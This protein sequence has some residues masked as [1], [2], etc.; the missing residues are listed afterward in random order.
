MNKSIEIL[1]ADIVCI[2]AGGTGLAAAVAAAE[3]G[4]KV[5]VLE[6][7][8]S[9][10]GNTA[11]AQGFFAAE[12]STQKRLKID[13]PKDAIFKMAMEY[14]HWKINPLIIRDFINKSDDTLLWLEQ[15][16]LEINEVWPLFPGQIMATMHYPVGGGKGLI[17]TLIKSGETLGVQLLFHTVPVKIL[18]FPNGE[19]SGVLAK[20]RDNEINISARAV[21]IGTGGFGGNKEWLKKYCRTYTE[22]SFSP[23]LPHMGDGIRLATEMGAATE[24]L[25]TLQW[26][27]PVYEGIAHGPGI[28]KEPEMIWINKNGER[29]TNEGTGL[30]H[31]ESVNAILRQPGKISFSVFDEAIKQKNIEKIN[32]GLIKFRG[33]STHSQRAGPADFAEELQKEAGTGRVKIS[34]SWE[35]I[36]RWMGAEPTVL[37]STIEKYNS[38]CESIYDRAFLK[39]PKYLIPIRTPPYYAMRCRPIFLTTIGGIKINHHME[40]L[41]KNN[42]PIPGLYAG[43]N[44]TGGWEEENCYNAFFSSH[45]VGFAINS[46][47]IAGENAVQYVS[48]K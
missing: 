17:Q 38:D 7:L 42:K 8:G 13:A 4:A 34:D 43:G 32:K 46:G 20:G 3:K 41:D 5:I 15:K 35:E 2:G 23:G 33:L 18:T 10:G 30:N 28:W 22:G 27:G 26:L 31:F 21:I 25:G 1:K 48:Q 45:A 47:R 11:R 37:K 9:P 16:G 40:V 19:I 39:D 12:S 44:D 29:Y 6:K 14:A 36:A 24:G